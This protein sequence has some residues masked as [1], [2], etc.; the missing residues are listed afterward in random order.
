MNT[1]LAVISPSTDLCHAGNILRFG[2]GCG[3]AAAGVKRVMFGIPE[4]IADVHGNFQ[5]RDLKQRSGLMA[6]VIFAASGWVGTACAGGNP[7]TGIIGEDNREIVSDYRPPWTAIGHVNAGGERRNRNFCTGTL[8]APRVVLTAGHCVIDAFKNT[9][10]AARDVHFVA[11]VRK[12]QSLG[13]ARGQCLKF[14]S[15]FKMLAP[16]RTLPDIGMQL[17]SLEFFKRNLAVIVLE[18]DIPKA[19]T[20]TLAQGGTMTPAESLVH[21]GYGGDRRY[22]LS[23][24]RS[25]SVASIDDG[26]AATTCDSPVASHGGPMFVSRAN[27]LRLAAVL[28]GTSGK[29]QA[30]L[31]V[32]V[33]EWPDVPLEATC[34]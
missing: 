28:V 12:D 33:S 9:P 3:P 6:L 24:D 15:G 23:A 27:E 19:G 30:T 14:P 29:T 10:L 32:P 13:H 8:I 25:C 11:R 7:K 22:R 2:R 17:V 5:R 18:A 26:L 21:A 4:R 1:R 16:E 34:P 31:A 20:A